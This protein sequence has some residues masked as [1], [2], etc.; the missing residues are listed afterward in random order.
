MAS[1]GDVATK[2]L[3]S[4]KLRSDSAGGDLSKYLA[5]KHPSDRDKEA[6]KGDIEC[7]LA[8]LPGMADMR[9]ARDHWAQAACCV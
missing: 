3:A 5:T 4:L 6:L 1:P 2:I 8:A 7:F 9:K